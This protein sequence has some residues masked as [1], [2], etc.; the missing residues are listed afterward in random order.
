MTLFYLVDSYLSFGD[1]CCLHLHKY[2]LW[3]WSENVLQKMFIPSIKIHIISSEKGCNRRFSIHSCENLKS[4][5]YWNF[6]MREAFYN[7]YN[8]EASFITAGPAVAKLLRIGH[9]FRDAESL[10]LLLLFCYWFTDRHV[11][12]IYV[13]GRDSTLGCIHLFDTVWAAP[14][15]S[16]GAHSPNKEGDWRYVPRGYTP[17]ITYICPPFRLTIVYVRTPILP[18]YAFSC[19]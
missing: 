1:T 17:L 19:V 10:C 5:A 2:C 8:S 9:A 7:C 4:Q 14:L 12:W 15:Y 6:E 3:R 18:N 16:P 13:L 11:L